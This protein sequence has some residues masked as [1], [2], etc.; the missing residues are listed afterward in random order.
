M[1]IVQVENVR[2]EFLDAIGELR[3]RAKRKNATVI[4]ILNSI[5]C[6]ELAKHRLYNK[7][8]ED[9]RF[10]SYYLQKHEVARRKLID[11]LKTELGKATRFEAGRTA[12]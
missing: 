1:A 5:S 7:E 4:A 8:E 11:R 3:K 6:E 9:V 2:A 10:D 12:C